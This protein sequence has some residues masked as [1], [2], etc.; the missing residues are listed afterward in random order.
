M[1][2]SYGLRD[3]LTPRGVEGGEWLPITR[4]RLLILLDLQFL[5]ARSFLG[6]WFCILA[7]ATHGMSASSLV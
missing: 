5:D 7:H 1:M 4:H 2:M 3:R 6:L